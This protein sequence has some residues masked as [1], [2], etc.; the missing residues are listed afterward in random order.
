MLIILIT[1]LISGERFPAR[2]RYCVIDSMWY[3]RLPVSFLVAAELNQFVREVALLP[4]Q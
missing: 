2:Q 3:E 1:I 4:A